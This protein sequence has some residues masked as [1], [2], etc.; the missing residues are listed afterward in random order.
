MNYKLRRSILIAVMAAAAVPVM[1]AAAADPKKQSPK[2]VFF[3]LGDGMAAAQVQ[4]AEAYRTH[5]NNGD[6]DCAEDLLTPAN[7]LIM[8]QL[9]VRGAATTFADTRFIT[10]SAAAA[11]AFACGAKTDIGVL[12]KNTAKTVSYKSIAELAQEQ[13]RAIGIV[14]SVSL[15]HATPAA[16]YANVDSRNDYVEIGWQAAQSGFEFFGGGRFRYLD[17]TDHS[18]TEPLRDEFAKAGYVFVDNVDSALLK[19]RKQKVI[20]SV[21]VSYDDD[22]MPYAI[23]QPARNFSLAEVTDCAI[24][25]LKNDSKGFFIMVEGGKIDW[26]GHANDAKANMMETLTFDD[27]VAVAV[28]FARSHP[29]DT[30]I[31]VTGDHETGGLSLGFAGTGYET[32]FE[33]FDR[34]NK[35]YDRF[36]AED[37]RP[38][39]AARKGAAGAWD[40]DAMNIDAEMKALME[41]GFGLVW[42][43]LSPAQRE[44]LEA[45]YDRSMGGGKDKRF[46]G[47]D[48][49]GPRDMDYLTYGGYDA[50]AVTLCHIMNRE[51]GI[52]WSSFSHT[53]V[54]VPV[55]A[56]GNGAEQFGGF[57][58]NSDIAQKLADIMQLGVELPVVE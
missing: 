24:Q 7:R 35:S 58:D 42:E 22:A 4:V 23:D 10:D 28:R 2:Y 11:T 19:S 56:A 52:A 49:D 16:Y 12:G 1:N 20:C 57:Y 26:A 47:Y 54:P 40:A 46:S 31:V 48:L 33:V 17:S 50:M 3:F 6:A 53:G 44:E 27:A 36:V 41:S 5:L 51:A 38:Y 45:A 13:G 9:P 14:S 37:L 25:R 30:L 32:A 55:F 15:P 29:N 39:K 34:Q 8:T 21:P 18:G 43:K